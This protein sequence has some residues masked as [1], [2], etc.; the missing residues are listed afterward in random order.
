M[1]STNLDPA[2]RESGAPTAASPLA[3]RALACVLTIGTFAGLAHIASIEII[4]A[5]TTR[6]SDALPLYLSACA[7]R[8]GLDPTLQ[9]SLEV[10]YDARHLDVGAA[11]FSNLY[12]ATAGVLLQS[13]CVVS[14]DTFEAGWRW[15]QLLSIA[16]FALSAAWI[17]EGDRWQRLAWG[18]AVGVVLAWHPVTQ[19]CVRLGQV[20]MVLAGMIAVA[21]AAVIRGSERTAGALLAIGGLVKLVP[22]AMLVPMLAARRFGAATVIVSV[23]LL[24]GAITLAWVPLARVLAGIAE[25]LAFQAAI[26]PD[27]LVGK[28]P[29]PG[30]MR[31]IG[32]ARHDALQWIA[33]GSALVIPALR[34]SRR[35][36]IAGIG[37]LTAWLGADAAGFHVLY[38]PLAFPVFVLLVGSVSR[39]AVLGATFWLLGVV[40]LPG[41]DA[42]P[43]MVLWGCVATALAGEA[44][45]RA[46]GAVVRSPLELDV[47]LKR[48]SVAMFGLLTGA[49]LVG[50]QPGD[51]PVAAPLPEGVTTPEGAGFIHP[52][53]RV[54]G[55]PG[56]EARGLGGGSD[57]AASTLVKPGT[58]RDVQ[59]YM[60]RAPL[61]W[62]ELATHYP[63][64]ADLMRAR[65]R[66]AP[67]GVLRDITGKEAAGW[68]SGDRAMIVQ[69][70]KEGLQL[71]ELPALLEA[72][73]ASGLGELSAE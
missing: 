73:W 12:P 8:D 49:L 25:T 53:D 32:Y 66:E 55:L 47:G 38:A 52:G 65:A 2:R 48:A 4:G 28:H 21:M 22:A 64:R 51:G 50:A 18:G 35:T 20:N 40:E 15:L 29:A 14:W 71:G 61:L 10:A 41:L 27:W 34:P 69:L 60:V 33:L 24:G 45:I 19:E 7:V 56:G 68:L 57:R 31:S 23:G 63:A 1:L 11:T 5:S 39:V 67:K 36:A 9:K 30:W 16:S 46:A 72:A 43:R 44:L 58:V 6:A 70:E 17:A 37:V 26:D 59:L 3:L 62:T 54:P 42:E 13:M